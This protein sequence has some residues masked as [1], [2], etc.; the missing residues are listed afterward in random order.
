MF[1]Q[2]FPQ[3]GPLREGTG[4]NITMAFSAALGFLGPNSI[5]PVVGFHG[6]KLILVSWRNPRWQD[7]ITYPCE[8]LLFT[9]RLYIDHTS[10]RLETFEKHR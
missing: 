3:V 10:T 5:V 7:G 6:S 2:D 9:Y 4:I 8:A 1:L